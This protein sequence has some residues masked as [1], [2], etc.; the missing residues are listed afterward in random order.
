[1]RKIFFLF[2]PLFLLISGCTSMYLPPTAQTEIPVFEKDGPIRIALVLGGGG[3]KGLAHLGAIRE[4]EAAGIRPD[5]IVG[6]SAGAIIGALYADDPD[7]K[8]MEEKLFSLRRSDLLDINFFARFGLV[9]GKSLEKFMEKNLR[10]KTF[11]DLKIPLI[12][13]ATDLFTGDLIELS[14]DAIPP[15][16]RASCSFPGVFKPVLLYGRYLIDGGAANP[17]PVEI[18]KKY[19]ADVIIAIDVSEKLPTPKPHHLFGVAKRGMEITCQKL[20][21]KSLSDADVVIKME[22]QDVGLFSDHMNEEIYAHGREKVTALLPQIKNFLATKQIQVP[23]FS[24]LSNPEK[25][26]PFPI[27]SYVEEGEVAVEINAP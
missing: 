21:E 23:V 19:G 11:S 14:H 6:C 1:M 8:G 18:A 13:A 9:Q 15:A 17:V 20:V 22:F 25:I 2:V 24:E 4:L 26:I 16:V 3:S 7:L 12:V 27:P 5:L 10:S